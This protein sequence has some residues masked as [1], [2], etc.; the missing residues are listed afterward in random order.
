VLLCCGCHL[1]ALGS[2]LRDQRRAKDKP[3]VLTTD[4]PIML[5]AAEPTVSLC[6]YLLLPSLWLHHPPTIPAGWSSSV[7]R[8]EMVS[9]QFYSA[10]GKESLWQSMFV[11]N[12]QPLCSVCNQ[13]N[14]PGLN[15]ASTTSNSILHGHWERAFNLGRNKIVPMCQQGNFER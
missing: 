10:R 15:Q 14:P 12:L 1:F 3:A 9:T 8:S 13:E 4:M 2:G 5:A 7:H 11:F 6:C